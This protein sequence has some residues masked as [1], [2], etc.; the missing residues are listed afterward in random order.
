[1]GNAFS[2]SPSSNT[3]FDNTIDFIATNYILTMDFKN[4]TKLS[5]KDYCE[6]LIILTSS[7]L[8]R[9]LTKSEVEYLEQR[10]KNGIEINEMA[11]DDIIFL[12]KD[13]VDR[14]DVKNDENKNIKK[15][16]MCIGIAK[17][18]IKI[19][20]IF[21]AIVMTINPIYNYTDE[22]GNKVKVD[23]YNKDKIPSGV[24]K[25][26]TN[27]NICNNRINA[28]QSRNT[29][30]SS[31]NEIK[32]SPKV[33]DININND[34]SLKTLNNEPGIPQLRE[35]YNDIYDYSTGQFIG[36][37]KDTK[38]EFNKDL[39]LFYEVFT[40]NKNMPEDIK[41]FSD[42]K[43]KDYSKTP[44]C[45]NDS[46]NNSYIGTESDILFKNYAD[47]IKV[48]IRNANLKQGKLLNIINILFRYVIDPHTKAKR[49]RINPELTGKLLSKT[50]DETR[51]LI[52]DLYLTCERDYIKGIQLYEAIINKIGFKTLNKQKEVLE[53]KIIQ[54]INMDNVQ[55]QIINRPTVQP[56][57]L[58]VNRLNDNRG[59][60]DQ[61]I[62]N[63]PARPYEK[64]I[65]EQRRIDEQKRSIQSRLI[66]EEGLIDEQKRNEQRLIDEQRR[67]DEQKRSI[68]SRRFDEPIRYN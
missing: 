64:S 28:L 5:E 48:M 58:E 29:N 20:H 59:F 50:V 33:C 44:G 24:V 2:S 14:L 11:T 31:N 61:P 4:L 56:S 43:L 52:T 41:D 37:S 62:I 66:Y 13:Q 51:H 7:I 60:Y 39:Q 1:M 35:L 6:K 36:M 38:Y 34:K 15:K 17:F 46:L 55:P 53:N 54:L 65:D 10:T 23:L 19:A 32:V 40:G 3:T 22:Y 16:R 26:V 30:E 21:S 42:I 63:N 57:Y 45:Q 8:D 12:E 25:K 49:V 18:Y 68:Q 67:I 47:N 27:I 9:Y